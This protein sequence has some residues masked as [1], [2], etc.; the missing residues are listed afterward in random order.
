MKIIL[1][2]D[3]RLLIEGLKRILRE[4]LK[5]ERIETA[6]DQIEF[7]KKLFAENWNLLILD[8]NFPGR[9]ALQI[10][11]DFKQKKFD[12]PVL[13]MSNYPDDIF[14]RRLYIEGASGYISG[15]TSIENFINAVKTILDG[16]KYF[17]PE[18]IA[19]VA[20]GTYK[21]NI[22]GELSN[23]EL[24]VFTKLAEG[25]TVG[26]IAGDLFLSVKT[27]STYRKNILDKLHLRN[28][29]EIIRY[30]FLNN[31]VE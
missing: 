1:V 22:L 27:I 18:I 5:I 11:S 7:N 16:E 28:N 12:L 14:S 2:N 17:H 30:A 6:V 8:L 10:L 15:N 4:F 13:V 23:R 19:D 31:L 3:H 25:K 21:K 20:E 29:S 26:E 24:L 9:N